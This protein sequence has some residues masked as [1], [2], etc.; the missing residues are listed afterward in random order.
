[1]RP[2][3]NVPE[4]SQSLNTDQGN[5]DR[6]WARWSSGTSMP[7]KSQSLN[8]DQ[9]NSDAKLQPVFAALDEES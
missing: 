3:V 9:G 6:R 8:T 5:S 4:R 1:M 7:E 2:N